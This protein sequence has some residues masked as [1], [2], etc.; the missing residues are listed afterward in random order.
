M[1]AGQAPLP[2]F[3]AGITTVTAPAGRSLAAA[4][5]FVNTDPGEGNGTAIDPED[6]AFDDATEGI[7]PLSISIHDVPAGSHQLGIRF[8][9]DNGT[10][11]SVRFIDFESENPGEYVPSAVKVTPAEI[12]ENLAAGV[13]TGALSTIDWDDPNGTGV[14]QYE[15]L[16]DNASDNQFFQLQGN[17]TLVATKGFD[18]EQEESIK[19][20]IRTTDDTN[21]SLTDWVTIAIA[22]DDSE[23]ED[24][25]GLSQAAETLAGTSDDDLDSDDDGFPDGVEVAAGSDPASATSLPN[26][27]PTDLLLSNASVMENQTVGT[28]VGD[29]N[30]TDPDDPLGRDAYQY[31]LVDGNG[32]DHNQIFSIDANG[33][34][35]TVSVL[36]H[37]ANATFSIRVRTKDEH[38]ASFEKVFAITVL[39][40]NEVPTV[41]DLSG[42]AVAEN[43]PAGT[44]VGN[45]IVTDPDANST[46]LIAFADGNGSQHN[47]LFTIDANGTLGTTTTFDY[48]TNATA[49]Y[50][51]V[52]AT[53]EDNASIEKA[54]VV[55]VTNVLEDLDGDGIE[56]HVDPD[57]DGDGFSD[58]AEIAYGSDPRNAASV[59]NQAPTL[60]DL[61]GSSIAENSNA[62]SVVGILSAT[63]PDAN[64]TITLSLRRRQ[65][66]PAQQPLRHRCQRHPSE[67][68][69]PLITRPTPQP[70]TYA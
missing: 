61:N 11:G 48:E 69:P 3:P 64:A 47:H 54:F 28:I 25:D 45:F 7:S 41:I 36:D 18:F 29:L 44:A 23:D 49:L 22:D 67:P 37:E 13:W 39:D 17:A 43:Q 51:R 35:K 60:L 27:A 57:D 50:I 19:L 9:D 46:H 40:A 62:G 30:A 8:R 34:L 31:N 63:D 14:Y 4:E 21:N 24:G 6:L 59:A 16:E 55:T 2:N 15:L 65:R 68:P 53:D 5:Y 20:K 42:T 52:K 10:W 58:A 56:D 33:T 70:C 1:T 38:N 32:S 26:Q 66:F 12:T